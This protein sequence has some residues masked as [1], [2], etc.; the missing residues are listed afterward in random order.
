M[1]TVSFAR[2]PRIARGLSRAAKKALRA[3]NTIYAV[4]IG[5]CGRIAQMGSLTGLLNGPTMRTFASER[6]VSLYPPRGVKGGRPMDKSDLENA[7]HDADMAMD[8]TALEVIFREL[9][10]FQ[11]ECELA[12][13]PKTEGERARGAS[14]FK[15][16]Q[17]RVVGRALAYGAQT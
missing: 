16:I 13:P 15:E 14:R 6:E 2:C 1:V 9:D 4:G 10:E 12:G 8:D 5:H 3:K 11:K 7:K 17:R